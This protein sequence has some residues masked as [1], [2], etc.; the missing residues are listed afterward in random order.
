MAFTT[1]ALVLALFTSTYPLEIIEKYVILAIFE[2]CR[3]S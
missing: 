2:C 3:A 1:A